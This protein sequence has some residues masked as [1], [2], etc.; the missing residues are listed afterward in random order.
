VLTWWV[1]HRRGGEDA[2]RGAEKLL[3]ATLSADS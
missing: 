2:C 3:A 1:Q